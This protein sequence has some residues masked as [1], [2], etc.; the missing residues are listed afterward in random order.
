MSV[1]VSVCVLAYRKAADVLLCVVGINSKLSCAPKSW[2]L[3]DAS[4]FPIFLQ[5]RPQ[6]AAV[7][8]CRVL[9][10]LLSLLV[11]PLPVKGEP[12]PARHGNTRVRM[13]KH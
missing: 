8:Y 10:F 7:I 2:Q 13:V 6:R 3:A 12:G 9:L 11:L 4:R 5:A 1:C